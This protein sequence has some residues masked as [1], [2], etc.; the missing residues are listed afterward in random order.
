VRE[1]EER[2]IIWGEGENCVD[3]GDICQIKA[4]NRRETHHSWSQQETGS[5]IELG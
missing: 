3:V 4:C 5:P 2:M 1:K